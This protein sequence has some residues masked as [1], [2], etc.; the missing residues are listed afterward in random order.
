M[1]DIKKLEQKLDKLIESE[2]PE[3]L[4]KW[5]KDYRAKNM[6]KIFKILDEINPT[7]HY[8]CKAD[9]CGC[10]GCVQINYTI[11][12]TR[13]L[14]RMITEEEFK[15]WIEHKNYDEYIKKVQVKKNYSVFVR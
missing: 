10:M 1:I 8:W 2:T 4:T 11:P 14:G 12:I 15:K 3:S 9:V 13:K 7:E 5:I 6:D